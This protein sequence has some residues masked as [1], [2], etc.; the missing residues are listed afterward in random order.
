[1]GAAIENSVYNTPVVGHAY[2]AGIAVLNPEWDEGRKKFQ[3]NLRDGSAY[4]SET[5]G[6]TAGYKDVDS[7]YDLGDYAFNTAAQAAP[8]IAS[9]AITKN[10]KLA[11]GLVYSYYAGDKYYELEKNDWLNSKG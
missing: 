4:I 9:M 11:M 6:E 3:E 8:L 7:W 2:K 1:M 10:P 5:M